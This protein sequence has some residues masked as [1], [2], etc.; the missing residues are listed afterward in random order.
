M[1]KLPRILIILCGLLNG[2]T[3]IHP[4]SVFWFED[5]DNGA[6]TRWT[7]ENA[8][9][10]G[11]NPTP[12]G[13]VGLVYGTNA[14]IEHDRFVIND[15][16]TPE[17]NPPGIFLGPLAAQG[18]F[19]R[20]RHYACGPP[21]N[22]PNPFIN[23]APGPNQ[24]LHITAYA[25]C[26]GLI[27][28]GTPGLD[29][30]NCIT[31]GGLDFP[32][33]KTEQ[34]ATLNNNIDATGQFGI[35]LTGDFFIGGDEEGMKA[36]SSILYSVNGGVT[37]QILADPILNPIF[38][39]A[40]TCDFGWS[41]QSFVLPAS[42]NNQND[43][44]IAF[45]WVE[46]GDQNT[47]FNDYALGA[48]FNV[49]NITLS[50]PVP[51]PIEFVSMDAKYMDRI[52]EISWTTASETNNDYFT[53]E[54]SGDAINFELIAQLDGAG[55]SNQT[56]MYSYDDLEPLE[57]TA[58]YRLKQTDFDGTVKDIQVVSV[59]GMENAILLYPNP[60]SGV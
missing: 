60:T 47:D 1:M 26:G 35:T 6:L 51:L 50:A 18:T 13:I 5:F 59:N 31:F 19:L 16:N 25:S 10:S 29:D 42:A 56:N 7:I 2:V 57:G 37:W 24:S 22:L 12:V 11:T 21:N 58:Y 4:Q 9:G 54:R 38:F 48:S 8:P 3:T 53:L 39:L 15:Q 23:S 41:H 52:V 46:D 17:L 45:R 20:G 44:R 49:D 36:H 30:W 40:G 27:Y 28:G 14:V 55:N 34:I 32:V 43:L 33:T